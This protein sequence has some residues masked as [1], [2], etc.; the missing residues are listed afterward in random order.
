MS[1]RV[2]EKAATWLTADQLSAW[3]AFRKMTRTLDARLARD[4]AR[5]G[6]LSMQDYDVLSALTVTPHHRW[7]AKHLSA[8]LLWTA[9]RMSH[10]IDR[11]E[12]R[13]L[14]R[15]EPCAKGRGTDVVLTPDGLDAIRAAAPEHVEAVRR[16]F[17]D[18]LT[19]EELAVLARISD[20]VLA[21]LE[22]QP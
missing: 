18:P 10:H 3:L 2:N 17:V 16:S 22:E 4:L 11:M 15:R 20:A 6:G 12:K 8:H 21:T 5:D 1:P 13:G 9:S 7:C 14:V 19:P